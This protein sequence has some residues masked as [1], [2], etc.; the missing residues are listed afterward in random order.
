MNSKEI[1]QYDEPS[2][3]ESLMLEEHDIGPLLE[4]ASD[5]VRPAVA[6][7]SLA[8]LV[9]NIELR[10]LLRS[11]N[12]YYT[13]RIEGEHARP[14][15]IE[16]AR[17]KNFSDNADLARKQ[18]LAIAHI[19]T[20]KRCEEQIDARA[21][22][23]DVKRWLFSAEALKWIHGKLCADIDGGDLASAAGSSMDPG[24][25]RRRQ[26]AVGQHEAPVFE[27]LPGLL[28]Q[29]SAAYSGVRRGEAAVVAIAASQHRLVWMQ[30]FM[31]GN[32]RL[33]RMHTHLLFHAAGLSPGLWS[34]VRG[35]A[36]SEQ[37]YR[38]LLHGADGNR[39]GDGRRDLA[40]A[41]LI[42]WIEYTLKTCIHQAHFMGTLLNATSMQDRISSA[43]TF[44]E[45]TLK[46]GVR[47]AALRA[48]HYLFSTQPELGRADFKAMTGLGDRVATDVLSALLKHGFLASDS[49]YGKVRFGI[50][51]RALRFYFPALWP[52]AEHGGA[53]PDLELQAGVLSTSTARGVLAQLNDNDKMHG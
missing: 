7:G 31:N 28:L 21:A 40:Q 30:P 51:M 17:Q 25:L 46:S 23:E 22:G 14:I 15:D 20:E 50:P 18:R 26:V 12:S 35:F 16:L 52:E 42:A 33:A 34:P 32:G 19:R 10:G 37:Q 6:I 43:L 29:W 11:M 49:P 44:E 9:A 3:I 47:H 5:L 4:L 2:Q 45:A 48:L 41:G 27:A 1:T 13:S 36:Q 38:D 24:Q 39:C 53:L 8:A